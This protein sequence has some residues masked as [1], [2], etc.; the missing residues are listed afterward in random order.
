MPPAHKALPHQDGRLFSLRPGK[1]KRQD[2]DPVDADAFWANA[3][4]VLTKV[5]DEPGLLENIG[6]YHTSLYRLQVLAYWEHF[7]WLAEEDSLKLLAAT[8]FGPILGCRA[9]ALGA[10]QRL[11][12]CK[13]DN[14]VTKMSLFLFTSCYSFRRWV[15]KD[16]IR[17]QQRTP[18]ARG[19]RRWPMTNR[20]CQEHG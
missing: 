9:C 7:V 13:L 5:L 15:S 4:R 8:M 11:L 18:S 16:Q 14:P 19:N 17:W 6:E 12:R 10:L 1:R 3:K 2:N 20:G